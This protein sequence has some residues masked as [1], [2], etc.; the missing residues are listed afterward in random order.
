MNSNPNPLPPLPTRPIRPRGTRPH[1][2]RWWT[3]GRARL[4]GSALLLIFLL[5]FAAFVIEVQRQGSLV[6]VQNPKSMLVAYFAPNPQ[7]HIPEGCW[8]TS[9]PQPHMVKLTSQ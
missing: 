8:R 3:M 5:V 6:L 1:N 7:M 4:Y 9:A 2:E